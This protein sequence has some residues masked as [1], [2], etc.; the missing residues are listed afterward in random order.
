[1]GNSAN[2]MSNT[3]IANNADQ[4]TGD[5]LNPEI[6]ESI[7]HLRSFMEVEEPYLNPS[8]SV[9][10][11][12]KQIKMPVRDLSILINHHL[13]Q[14]FFDFINEYRIDKAKEIL[15]DPGKKELTVLEILYDVG[16]NSKSSFNTAFKKYTHL[17]P[18][19]YRRK[20]LKT[21]S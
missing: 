7:T 3:A 11:L 17:T 1:M 10:D 9:Y 18:T 13:N 6:E 12:S 20:Y 4:D 14:H 8:I 5:P 21:A 15:Q 2:P 19:E 16:F